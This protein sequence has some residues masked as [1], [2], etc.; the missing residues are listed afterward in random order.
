MIRKHLVLISP[1]D[2]N[3]CLARLG[4]HVDTSFFGF[5]TQ[6]FLGKLTPA[7]LAIHKRIHYRNGFQTWLEATFE[8]FHG[9]T[10]LNT[11][12]GM[13]RFTIFFGFFWFAIV[14]ISILFLSL[15]TAIRYGGSKQALP[16]ILVPPGMFIFGVILFFFGRW[17]ARNE[18]TELL[19]FLENTIQSTPAK[20]AR[21][22]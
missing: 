21:A 1:H 12:I 14:L 15:P 13:N 18:E 7:R 4:P 8:P 17:L 2:V 10:R 6:P 5:G 19:T 3:E 16:G 9:G 11:D 22:T 20:E